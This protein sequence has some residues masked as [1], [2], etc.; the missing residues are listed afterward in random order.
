MCGSDR[1]DPLYDEVRDHYGV[2]P[3]AYRF[4]GCTA[5]GSATLDPLPSATTLAML[6]AP[7]YTFKPGREG[8][9]PLRRLVARLEWHVFYR[10]VCRRRLAVVHHL[11]GLSA[12]RLLEVGCG[13]GHFLRYLSDAGYEV[14]GVE[15]SATDAEYAR[16]RLGLRVF[17][18][19]LESVA[20]ERARYDGVLLFYVLEHIP[21]PTQTL[22]EVRR[23]LKPGGWVVAGLPVL[24]SGQSRL[25]GPRWSAVTEAP[26]HVAIPTFEGARRLLARA[27]FHHVRAAPS[28]LLENAG[29]V[30]LSLLPA[31]ATPQTW[32]RSGFLS[33]LFRRAAGAAMMVPGLMVAAAERLPR[34][35]RCRTGTMIFGGRT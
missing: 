7:D 5:C 13:S 27:G 17:Q 25:F 24:D 16:Q 21:D 2:S 34:G 9:F 35:G 31:A 18:G 1:L 12:G 23:I 15:L 6:Y 11:T 3:G 32:G 30:A 14:E 33:L 8:V 26:R 10:T 28:P 20:L 22:T 4:L 19:S 29:H